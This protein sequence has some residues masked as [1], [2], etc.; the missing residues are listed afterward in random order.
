M[1][2]SAPV[3]IDEP[4]KDLGKGAAVDDNPSQRTKDIDQ[5]LDDLSYA[6]AA[7]L[8]D[9]SWIDELEADLEE[10]VETWPEEGDDGHHDD[11]DDDDDDTWDNWNGGVEDRLFGL[12]VEQP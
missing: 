1:K 6:D 11:A 2:A 10:A 5:I 9:E 8:P 7:A 3:V 4:D 12:H